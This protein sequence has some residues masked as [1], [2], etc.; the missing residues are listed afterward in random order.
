MI[1]P[2]K[3]HAPALCFWAALPFSWASGVVLHPKSQ[4]C[5]Y[6]ARFLCRSLRRDLGFLDD[7][8]QLRD[9]GLEVLAE[10]LGGAADDDG[11]DGR[12]FFLDVGELEDL[13]ELA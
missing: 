4:G 1:A 10:L 12:L 11:A 2:R 3:N 9:L 7:T 13:V 6:A 5:R 8:R